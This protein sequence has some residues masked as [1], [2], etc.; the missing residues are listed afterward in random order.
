MKAERNR[1]VAAMALQKHVRR[2]FQQLTRVQPIV[3]YVYLLFS[4]AVSAAPG[5]HLVA[6][7]TTPVF[8]LSGTLDEFGVP[9]FNGDVVSFSA[10]RGG[11]RGIYV[12]YFDGFPE[13][14]KLAELTDRTPDGDTYLTLAEPA[15]QGNGQAVAFSAQT[16]SGYGTFWSTGSSVGLSTLAHA[17]GGTGDCM[18]VAPTGVFY[19]GDHGIFFFGSASGLHVSGPITSPFTFVPSGGFGATTQSVDGALGVAFAGPTASSFTVLADT[20][21]TV[22]NTAEKFRR[23]RQP[24]VD[25]HG[26]VVFYGE[27]PTRRGLYRYEAQHLIVIADS[28]T[29][30]PFTGDKFSEFFGVALDDGATVFIAQPAFHGYNLYRSDATGLHGLYTEDEADVPFDDGRTRRISFF[31][32]LFRPAAIANHR[33]AV[34][35]KLPRENNHQAIVLLD[36]SGAGSSGGTGGSGETERPP[37]SSS[38]KHGC[39][40]SSAAALLPLWLLLPWP[41]RLRRRVAPRH[42][43]KGSRSAVGGDATL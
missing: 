15:A 22:P 31:D 6:D 26:N 32:T 2:S 38:G 25:G 14:R 36:V 1:G 34:R 12:D 18:A 21:T 35:T 20:N 3:V 40:G 30:D 28:D 19:C 29:N 17:F 27:G 13:V 7:T 10:K 16:S 42:V 11:V 4:A 43:E 41:K 8:G 39:S 5:S 37:S 33:L 9:G 24:A 23:F